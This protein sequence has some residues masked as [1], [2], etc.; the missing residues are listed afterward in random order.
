MAFSAA[1]VTHTFENADGSAAVGTVTFTLTDV[2]TNGTTTI[3]PS[4]ITATLDASG[5][6]SQALTSNVDTATWQL[7]S[8]A[9]SG[10]FELAYNDGQLPQWTTAIQYNATAAQIA[11]AFASQAEPGGIATPGILGFTVVVTGGPLGSAPVSIA[12]VPGN[13]AFQVSNSTLAGGTLTVAQTVQ[14][15]VPAAPQNTQWR[16]DLRVTG[17]SERSFFITVPAGGGSVDLF[18]LI[19][20]T[21]QVGGG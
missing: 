2:M 3:E 15:T 1:T 16:V 18:S 10:S 11:A 21:Q 5:N 20:S 8:T 4:V 19:P 7:T 6:L 14:G 9:T 13:G 12:G 17:A